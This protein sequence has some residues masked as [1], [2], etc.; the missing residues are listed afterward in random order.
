ME[1]EIQGLSERIE[2]LL[3]TARKLADDNAK[4][5]TALAESRKNNAELQQRINEARARVESAL[6][7]LPLMM[8]DE[9]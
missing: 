1:Q 7:R 5:R 2:R 4:L 3:A 6:S 9:G 8:N